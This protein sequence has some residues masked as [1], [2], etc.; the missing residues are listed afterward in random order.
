MVF[1][2]EHVGKQVMTGNGVRDR[3]EKA[4]QTGLFTHPARL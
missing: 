1:K 4:G 3:F 2:V